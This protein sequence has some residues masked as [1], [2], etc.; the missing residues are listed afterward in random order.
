MN[1][2]GVLGPRG[3]VSIDQYVAHFQLPAAKV[4]ATGATRPMPPSIQ[5]DH[6]TFGQGIECVG[7]VIDVTGRIDISMNA[8]TQHL[9]DT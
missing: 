6:I 4:G 3:Q 5:I 8:F 9:I 2:V 7:K 1:N